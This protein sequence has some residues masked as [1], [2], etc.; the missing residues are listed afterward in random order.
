MKKLA[1]KRI[2]YLFHVQFQEIQTNQGM[3]TITSM[4][5]IR[6]GTHSCKRKRE[7]RTK[8][9]FHL[10]HNSASRLRIVRLSAF[11]QLVHCTARSPV[12]GA[13]I[14]Q[15][16]TKKERQ[17]ITVRDRDNSPALGMRGPGIVTCSRRNR[18]MTQTSLHPS[19]S[20]ST[21][22]DSALIVPRVGQRRRK[23][24]G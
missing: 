22:P 20:K 16:Q 15:Q 18:D 12:Q 14:R 2:I 24:K 21:A 6:S 4:L 9:L 23:M 17:G 5:I 11:N 8:L 10:A 19:T 13:F 3:I 1:I 7:S